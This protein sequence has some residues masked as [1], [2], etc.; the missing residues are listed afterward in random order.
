MKKSCINAVLCAQCVTVSDTKCNQLKYPEIC[1]QYKIF[2]IDRQLG[3]PL[4]KNLNCSWIILRPTHHFWIFENMKNNQSF[5]I[6]MNNEACPYTLHKNQWHVFIN[7]QVSTNSVT[8]FRPNI[9]Y[10]FFSGK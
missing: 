5:A 7:N 10:L 4:Y 6:S 1:G 9:S 2:H 3:K 8:F